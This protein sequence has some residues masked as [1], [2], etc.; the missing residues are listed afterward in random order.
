MYIITSI[1]TGYV[2]ADKAGNVITFSTLRDADEAARLIGGC[3][4]DLA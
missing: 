1:D 2:L 3:E 4:V